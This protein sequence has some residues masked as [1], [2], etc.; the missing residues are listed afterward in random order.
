MLYNEVV[1]KNVAYIRAQLIAFP[2]LMKKLICLLAHKES[3]S[4]IEQAFELTMNF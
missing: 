2:N 1:W 3:L 4:S